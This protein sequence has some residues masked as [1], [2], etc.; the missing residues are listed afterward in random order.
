ML[1]RWLPAAV[2]LAFAVWA[3]AHVPTQA[4]GARRLLAFS[5]P[6]FGAVMRYLQTAEAPAGAVLATDPLYGMAAGRPLARGAARPYQAD[7]YGG[8]LYRNLGLAEKSWAEVWRLRGRVTST[9]AAFAGA[10][11]QEDALAAF[12]AAE[13]VVV[14]SRARRQW[15]PATLVYIEGLSTAVMT[16]GDA[17]VRRR[18]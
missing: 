9:E 18:P 16:V 8:M 4:Q 11:A 6:A 5:K 12:A 17:T 15:T 2:G 13:I 14:D 10:P 3:A 7:S 1:R